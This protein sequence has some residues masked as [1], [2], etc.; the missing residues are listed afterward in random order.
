M[1]VLILWIMFTQ[2]LQQKKG[3]FFLFYKKTSSPAKITNRKIH[4]CWVFWCPIV[5][6]TMSAYV[7]FKKSNFST[8]KCPKTI[9]AS[10]L[11][12]CSDIPLRNKQTD[13]NHK[14]PCPQ[15]L[16]GVSEPR[17]LT[18]R[19]LFKNFLISYCHYEVS[20]IFINS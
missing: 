8:K 10:L 1:H 3:R 14:N 4:F 13:K 16:P 11:P 5:F 7:F 15:S 12:Q 20:R 2:L 19:R 17:C 6:F 9:F 18:I